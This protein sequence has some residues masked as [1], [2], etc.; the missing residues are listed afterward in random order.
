M[1]PEVS[2]SI[3]SSKL[4]IKS[5]SSPIKPTNSPIKPT[6]SPKGSFKN[7]TKQ[8]RNLKTMY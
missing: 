7:Q 5:T 4:P 3:I 8:L 2:G 6:N 1:V